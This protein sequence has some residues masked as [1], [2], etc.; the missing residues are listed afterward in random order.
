M[1]ST[2]QTQ[3]PEAWGQPCRASHPAPVAPVPA[4]TQGLVW[5]RQEENTQSCSARE[6]SQAGISPQTLSPASPVPQAG[7]FGV[8]EPSSGEH[9][10]KLK[11]CKAKHENILL[12]LPFLGAICSPPKHQWNW[13]FRDIQAQKLGWSQGSPQPGWRGLQTHLVRY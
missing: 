10:P 11:P 2:G 4:R 12:F 3:T 9:L 8:K 7:I 13:H 5:G 6:R 1:S